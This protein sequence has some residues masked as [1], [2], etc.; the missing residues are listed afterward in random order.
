MTK[1]KV[2]NVVIKAPKGMSE[3]ELLKIKKRLGR[4][5]SA[6]PKRKRPRDPDEKRV[7]KEWEDER[8]GKKIGEI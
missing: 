7:L 1:L 3:M 6:S 2:D 8:G 4:D 5:L